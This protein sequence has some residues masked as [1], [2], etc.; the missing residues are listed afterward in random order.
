MRVCVLEKSHRDRDKHDQSGGYRP[1]TPRC[2]TV[3]DRDQEVF[4]HYQQ[5]S[6]IE[7][8]LWTTRHW[9]AERL[10]VY[11]GT[12]LGKRLRRDFVDERA[13]HTAQRRHAFR[14]IAV[15]DDRLQSNR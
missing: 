4:L 5:G 12:G 14:R 6:S 7:D 9:C 1:I 10:G 3:I 8:G 13:L 2:T 15:S 11:V